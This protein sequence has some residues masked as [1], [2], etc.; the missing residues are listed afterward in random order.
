MAIAVRRPAA[1]IGAA[2]LGALTLTTAATASADED[3]PV[4]DTVLTVGADE[5]QRNVAWYT[6]QEVTGSV[7]WAPAS[8]VE[9]DS[10][11]AADANEAETTSNGETH[12]GRYYHHATMEGLEESTDYVYRVGGG[13]DW[14]PTY[15]FSTGAFDSRDLEFL[16]VG[17]P[18]MGSS[19]DVAADQEGWNATL[20]TA[21]EMFPDAAWVHSMGDQVEEP[22]N[23]DE[24]RALLAPGA[25][26]SVPF[27][28]NRGNHDADS[29][30]YA[31]HFNLPGGEEADGYHWYRHGEVLVIGVDSN[32]FDVEAHDDFIAKVLAEQGEDA[33]W[34]IVTFHHPAFGLTEH[35]NT[36]EMVEFRETIAP[37]LSAHGIDLALMGHDHT[38]ARSPL[39]EGRDPVESEDPGDLH[40]E[41]GQ[42]LYLTV[43]SSSGSKYYPFATEDF[44]DAAD[45]QGFDFAQV[46]WQ[47]EVPSFSHVVVSGDEM[48]IETY[49]TDSGE[50][51]DEVVLHRAG[52][53]EPSASTS[54]SPSPS[55][56]ALSPSPTA[57][58]S[59]DAGAEDGGLPAGAIAAVAVGALAL[60]GGGVALWRRRSGGQEG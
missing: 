16:V 37:V 39:M 53:P 34:H 20:D 12:D 1:A 55:G 13:D 50:A 32:S 9:G 5:T 8:A 18:Q 29:T 59:A 27:A 24:Y 41:E 42:T 28:F 31:T 48:T 40:P 19:G 23:E 11:P 7:Q 30:A 14:S 56:S 57:E 52:A 44:I 10:F 17:D 3:S 33:A 25:L 49:R 35:S 4:T 38:Y 43:N 22:S 6:P 26:R 47:E 2:L 51:Y 60:A 36:E 46:T 58:A 45:S 21:L 54:P 15:E